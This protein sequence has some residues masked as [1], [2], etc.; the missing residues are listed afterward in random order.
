MSTVLP[1]TAS[2]SASPVTAGVVP[3]LVAASIGRPGRVQ[4]VYIECPTWCHVDH[5]E[6]RE[7]AVEDI[8]HYGPGGGLQVPTM[9]NDDYAVHEWYVNIISDPAD[10]DP[11]MRAAHLVVANGSPNDAHLTD[12]QGEELAVELERMAADIRAAL[13]VCRT[14][15]VDLPKMPAPIITTEI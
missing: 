10:A 4:T 15:N 1:S 5:L 11:R 14:A 9:L 2:V 12:E 8:T 3:R 6:N 13:A 7:V